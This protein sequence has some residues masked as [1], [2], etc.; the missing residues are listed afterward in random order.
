MKETLS[1]CIYNDTQH[2]YNQD[3]VP[4]T[5][6]KE[7]LEEFIG[8]LGR[9]GKEAEDLEEAKKLIVIKAKENFGGKIIG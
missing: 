1:D 7:H 6:L 8:W 9:E 3:V 2:T 5:K 4:V